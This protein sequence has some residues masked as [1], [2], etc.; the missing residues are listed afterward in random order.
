MPIM[1]DADDVVRVNNLPGMP[2]SAVGRP[3]QR[4][5]EFPPEKLYEMHA[6]PFKHRFH[7]D[8]AE[9]TIWGYGLGPDI[10]GNTFSPGP[11]FKQRYG[12]PI[13]TRVYNDLPPEGAP[14]G[15]GIPEVT[16]HLHNHH[17][18]SESDGFPGDF[19]PVG[20]H[21]DHHYTNILAG[22]DPREALNTLWY[23]DHR[24]DFTA[25]N[26]YK[27][28]VGQWWLYDKVDSGNERDRHRKALRLP[29]GEY[30]VPMVFADKTF[31]ATPS[32][33]LFMDIFNVDGFLGEQ[34]TVNGAVQPYFEVK[35][36]K[37]RFRLLNVGP[38]RF[39][40]FALF[41][42]TEAD[43]SLEGRHGDRKSRGCEEGKHNRGD[44]YENGRK[45]FRRRYRHRRRCFTG[46]ITVIANDGNLL[47]H[48]VDLGSVRVTPAERIDVVVDFRGA[49]TGDEIYL[50]NTMDQFT[51]GG[52]TGVELSP[53]EAPGVV[54]FIVKR[55]VR[56]R[57][58]IPW[59]L[60]KKPKIKPNEIVRTRIFEFDR[61][62]DGWTING[63]RFDFTRIDETVVRGTAERWI[64]R[65][66]GED[67][68]HPVHIHLEEHQ[69]IS[70]SGLATTDDERLLI[71]TSRK[72][73]SVIDPG[74]ELEIFLRFRDWTGRYPI[75]CH[76]TV[77]EDHAMM[78]RWEV[79][80]P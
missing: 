36:R 43:E 34:L 41:R 75:H 15:F 78:L 50:V 32:H 26:T 31:D 25:Q 29:S 57:S 8:L 64:L 35:R 23:H 65:N 76:N 30:D 38:S 27:G 33:Q 46:E 11:L 49:K 20:E 37:Y 14:D 74:E 19:Y 22:G 61:E 62:S 68:A 70:R 54:K 73:V 63:K 17:T 66:S 72:D 28:L 2:H 16:T 39:Y 52:P 80:D 58:K 3:H 67:W 21:H 55:K 51:G 10:D 5:D 79:V 42:E 59:K 18:A 71:E 4:F 9:S 60:R 45:E 12:E 47:P 1:P 56:D 44:R 69:I 13:V 40:K 53:D 7:P 48:P 24:A 77:H 6:R